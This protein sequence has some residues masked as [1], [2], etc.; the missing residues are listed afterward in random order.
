MDAQGEHRTQRYLTAFVVSYGVWL[1]LV[2]TLNWQELLM[3]GVLSAIVA[4]FGWRYFSQ[5]GFSRLSVKKLLYLIVYIPV[6]FWAMIKANFD[7]AYRVI[8]PRMPIHPGVVLI[9]T[10]LKSD[11]GKL[12]LANSITLTPGTLTMDVKGNSMLVHWI[13]VKSTDTEEAT[14]IISKR[15]ERY[16]KVI[17]S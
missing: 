6:F 14:R 2:G 4:A 11:S 10:D 7:V 16:L 12:A 9:K 15:F 1:A 5:V 8:H 3:G 13:N 17:F